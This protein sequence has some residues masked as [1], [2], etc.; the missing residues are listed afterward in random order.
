MQGRT[1]RYDEILRIIPVS[2][3]KLT[4]AKMIVAFVLSIFLY[5]FLFFITLLVEASMHFSDLSWSMVLHLMK[6][7]FFDGIGVF[8]AIAPIIAA[9]SYWKKSYWLALVLAELYSFGGLFMSVSKTLRAFYPITAVFGVSGYYETSG[10]ERLESSAV[11]L[12]CGV[13]S[14]VLLS[15]LNY[16]GGNHEKKII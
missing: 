5:L 7:Y 1:G 8:F 15:G 10:L 9:I 6:M 2:E 14:F 12:F 13:I 16:K 11:L 4:I 3:M